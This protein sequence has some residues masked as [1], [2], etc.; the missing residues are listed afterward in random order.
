MTERKK[1]FSH[2]IVNEYKKLLIYYGNPLTNEY[3]FDT[4]KHAHLNEF[5]YDFISNN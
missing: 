1:E 2:M 3:K 4:L 5:C